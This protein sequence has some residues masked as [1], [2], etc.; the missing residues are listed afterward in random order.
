[1]SCE[2]SKA[3]QI[4][5]AVRSRFDKLFAKDSWKEVF[6][7]RYK[8]VFRE[9]YK[10]IYRDLLFWLRTR[11]TK[12]KDEDETTQLFR[13]L[14]CRRLWYR[15]SDSAS[16]EESWDRRQK[17]TTLWNWD[18]RLQRV[19]RREDE[20]CRCHDLCYYIMISFAMLHTYESSD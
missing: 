17:A 6:C 2:E 1:M 3:Q 7:K 13:R 18:E 19:E 8:K 9:R 15:K 11:R 5:Q 12:R 16:E 4:W 14:W 20:A 10:E